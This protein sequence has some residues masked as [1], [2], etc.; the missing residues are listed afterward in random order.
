M[1]DIVERRAREF[2][3]MA[4]GPFGVEIEPYTKIIAELIR[5]VSKEIYADEA[6]P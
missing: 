6:K 4:F 3:E 5:E 2:C 1:S